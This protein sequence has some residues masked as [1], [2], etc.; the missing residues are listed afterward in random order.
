MCYNDKMVTKKKTSKKAVA[1]KVPTA[2]PSF[3][4]QRL[5]KEEPCSEGLVGALRFFS[6]KRCIKAPK[7]LW[8]LVKKLDD[9]HDGYSSGDEME[10]IRR[11]IKAI[12][13]D[14]E[15]IIKPKVLAEAVYEHEEFVEYAEK[16]LSARAFKK[17]EK[18][19]Y[20]RVKDKLV[21]VSNQYTTVEM[22][23]HDIAGLKRELERYEKEL[24]STLL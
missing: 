7:S 17:F 3:C 10:E 6:S 22:I 15:I 14:V 19:A 8:L 21:S 5:M 9:A 12:A 11:K 24:R 13:D 18:A 23:E 4:L 2:Q 20:G 16:M 1:K